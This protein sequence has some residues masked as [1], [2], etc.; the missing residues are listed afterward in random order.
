MAKAGK[1]CLAELQTR[2]TVG[3]GLPAIAVYQ[4]QMC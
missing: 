3:A 2:L 4:F 1:H